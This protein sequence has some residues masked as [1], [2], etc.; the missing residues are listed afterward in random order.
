MTTSNP[1]Y[2]MSWGTIHGR[3]HLLAEKHCSKVTE[4]IPFPP[5]VMIFQGILTVNA[6]SDNSSPIAGGHGAYQ[7]PKIIEYGTLREVTLTVGNTR[8]A[9]AD[10]ALGGNNDKTR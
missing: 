9:I 4:T 8:L 7:V 5:L 2:T 6:N 1:S 10:G 3:L